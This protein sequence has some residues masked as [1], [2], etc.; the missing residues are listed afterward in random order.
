MA[1]ERGQARDQWAGKLGFML[2]AIGSAVGLGNIWRYPYIAYENGGGAFLVPYFIALV[3]AGIPVLILEYALGHKYRSA[4]PF[5]FRAL[6]QRWEWL[7]WWQIGVSFFIITYYMVI[8][9]W[10]LS[11]CYYS[12]GTRWGSDPDTFFNE[13]FLGLSAGFWE[14]GGLQWRVLLA[15]A[16]AW[17]LTYWLLQRG[18][19]R[20]I[21][22]A[23]K[24]LIPALVVMILI[25]V[26]RGLTLPGAVDGLNVLLTPDFSALLNPSVW[27]AA[28]GQIFFSLS[29]GFSIMIAYA[30]Y[31][32]RR[33]DLTNSA[34]IVAL[35]NTGFEFLA[36][37]GVFSVLGFL[38]FQQNATVDEV[39]T[40]GIGL[41]FVAFPQIINELPGL[42]SFF[43]VIFFGALLFAGVTSAVSILECAI[44]GVREKFGLTR[45]A[46]VNW[47][48]GL[49]ALVSIIYAT[50]GGLYYLDVVDRWMNN[51]G[52][53][54]TGLAE[55]L[56]VVF[57]VRRLR[58]LQ[59]H[60]NERSY[61]RAGGWWI[62]AL[63]AVT[64][65]LLGLVT[66]L[67]LYGELTSRYGEYPL[68]GLLVFG[69]GLAVLVVVAGFVFQGITGREDP[70]TA[71][72]NA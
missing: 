8:I 60:V 33:S 31:L 46:A 51:Y 36:A 24:I 9:G 30:S 10:V 71:E 19:S 15:T 66:I 67:N 47:V 43:G 22:L 54:L 12:F 48:C 55:I 58:S 62:I 40:S 3:T 57:V 34:F 23:S 63:T 45:R 38:A 32:N 13:S 44:A 37:L 11:Y 18:V 7:G 2:A 29:V 50:R 35:S 52:L 39:V 49:A 72:E 20:G 16:I 68:S 42:N 53:V 65:A 28:Y 41:A 21:E 25:F 17:I 1:E 56:F 4:A 26:V 61:I 6:S 27:V 70:A 64:P 69:W 5:S 14:F 59:D